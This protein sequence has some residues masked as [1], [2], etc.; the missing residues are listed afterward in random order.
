MIGLISSNSE[1][2]SYA[3]IKLFRATQ[4]DVSN[5]QPLLQVAFWCIGEFGDLLIT[6][7][8]QQPK[9]AS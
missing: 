1:L 6:V 9:V 8:D 3:T 7:S 2:Q 4:E 5:A